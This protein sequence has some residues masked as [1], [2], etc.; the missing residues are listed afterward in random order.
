MP[1][2]KQI[3][4]RIQIDG[5]SKGNPGP[6]GIGVVIF[7]GKKKIKEISKYITKK[8]NNQ[9]EYSAAIKALKEAIKLKANKV[10]LITDSELLMKQIKGIYKIKSENLLD[11]YNKLMSLKEKFK[12]FN[13]IW[14]SR[15]NNF[16]ADKL[17]K[18]A[19]QK[20]AK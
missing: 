6:A 16:I 4:L 11:F 3:A 8:T 18:S 14:E 19:A 15:Q 1:K 5:A 13:I 2:E 20:G 10:T 9:A 12:D 17:A 7:K